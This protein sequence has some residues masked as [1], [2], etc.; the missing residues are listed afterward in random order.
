MVKQ[1]ELQHD[2]ARPVSA[3]AGILLA[4]CPTT[5]LAQVAG[6]GSLGTQVNGAAIAPVRERASSPK[7]Q[8]EAAICFTAFASFPCPMRILPDLSPLQPFKM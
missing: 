5:T 4:F 2:R 6:D 7:A 1:Q 3:I 8:P